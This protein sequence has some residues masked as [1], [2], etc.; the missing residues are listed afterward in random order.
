VIR[1]PPPDACFLREINRAARVRALLD[2]SLQPRWMATDA[3]RSGLTLT[4]RQLASA[5]NDVV[6]RFSPHGGEIEPRRSVEAWTVALRP[7]SSFVR[8]IR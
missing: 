8:E 5:A 3:P 7:A 4:P 6:D 1:T 2:R